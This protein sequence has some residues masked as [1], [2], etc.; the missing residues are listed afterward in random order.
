MSKVVISDEDAAIILDYDEDHFR[1]LKRKEI[2][3]SKLS[4]SVSSFCNT[5]GG[6]IFVGIAER[7]VGGVKNRVWDG[8]ADIEDANPIFQVL[9]SLRPMGG[10]YTY[11]FLSNPG[12]QGGRRGACP[13]AVG[14]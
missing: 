5:V 10:F 11:Q 7:D 4:Q 13:D 3:P 1:D 9:E 6:E 14:V 12:R 8:F 2:A